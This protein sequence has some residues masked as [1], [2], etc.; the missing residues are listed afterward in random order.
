M[1]QLLRTSLDNI[2][3]LI[4]GH[5]VSQEDEDELFTNNNVLY[6]QTICTRCSYP[7][8]LRRNPADQQED[9]YMLTEE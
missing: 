6:L 2:K 8:L 5:V 4:R 1:R 9:Y 7:L 3:C